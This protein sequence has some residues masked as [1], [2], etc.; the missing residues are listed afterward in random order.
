MTNYKMQRFNGKSKTWEDISV[1]VDGIPELREAIQSL[2][3]D[4][5][6]AIKDL[7][8]SVLA[9]TNA[10]CQ[11]KQEN[12]T[13]RIKMLRMANAIANQLPDRTKFFVDCIGDDDS[14]SEPPLP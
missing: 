14:L 3:A 13:Q 2:E 10:V 1:T 4:V 5:K 6:F 9:I 7:R 12:E 8:E 11:L